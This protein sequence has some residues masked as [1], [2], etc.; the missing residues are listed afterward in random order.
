MRNTPNFFQIS[1]SSSQRQLK[2]KSECLGTWKS[3]DSLLYRWRRQN[4]VSYK[5]ETSFQPVSISYWYVLLKGNRQPLLFCEDWEEFPSSLSTFSPFKA[6]VWRAMKDDCNPVALK[7]EGL[8]E[9]PGGKLKH[10]LLPPYLRFW[11][12]R[13]EVGPE[14][15]KLQ[16]FSECD[17][18]SG[19]GRIPWELLFSS[20]WI[21]QC[22][23][24]QRGIF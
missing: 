6:R 14:N 21:I 15:S 8:S 2:C 9:P 24:S 18:A 20:T 19:L 11:S 23:D 22:S 13:S 17:D 12:C 16:E 5:L 7:P 10:R 1:I 4:T 3:C